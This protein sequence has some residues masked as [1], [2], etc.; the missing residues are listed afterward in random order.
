MIGT[1][2]GMCVIA[3]AFGIPLVMTNVL[4]AYGVYHFTSKDLFI[5]RLCFSKNKEDHLNF[6]ELMS[7]PVSTATGQSHFDNRNIH[8]IENKADEIKAL[9]EEMLEK[10]TGTLQ[11]SEEDEILQKRFRKVTADCGK[12]Y[13]DLNIVSQ[14][15]IGRGFL[16]KH[17]GL[18]PADAMESVIIK[19][20]QAVQ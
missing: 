10:C 1:S 15:R 17:A 9:V 3:S 4:P 13:G 18:L 2:S 7:P 8:I 20:R 19:D 16:R 6:F 14:A 12:L 5:P 11:Y